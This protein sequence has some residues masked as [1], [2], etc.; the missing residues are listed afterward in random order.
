MVAVRRLD[1]LRLFEDGRVDDRVVFAGEGS[2]LVIEFSQIDP[3]GQD[4]AKWPIRQG[5][6]ALDGSA[7]DL[8]LAGDEALGAQGFNQRRNGPQFDI[9][10]ERTAVRYSAG[11]AFAPARPRSR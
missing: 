4:R 6:A 8:P 9:A 1:P 10:P 3:V 7:L 11:T 5:H 2:A